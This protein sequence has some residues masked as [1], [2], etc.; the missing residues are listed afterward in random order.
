NLDRQ[1]YYR[2]LLRMVYRLLFLFVAEDRSLLLLPEATAETRD[3]YTEY[4]STQ[5]LRLLAERLRGTGRHPDLFQQLRLVLGRLGQENGC[6]ELGLPALGGFLFSA[7]ACP[8]L[9]A[10]EL[11]N[12]DLLEA[13]RCLAVTQEGG[14]RTR[15]DYKNLAS[16]EMG[17]VY[18]SLL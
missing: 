17:S 3:L 15:V 4:Y 7:D 14:R 9:D 8:E 1:G 12:G 11:S 16:E 2:L 13:I 6:P 18:E 5:R 10:C